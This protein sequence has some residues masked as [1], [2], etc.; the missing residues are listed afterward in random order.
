[1]LWSTSWREKRVVGETTAGREHSLCKGRGELVLGG[2]NEKKS[3]S[4]WSWRKRRQVGEDKGGEISK[5]GMCQTSA[6]LTTARIT[7]KIVI[8]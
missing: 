5:G 7:E 1:M 2:G 4:D 8:C 3:H 6:V